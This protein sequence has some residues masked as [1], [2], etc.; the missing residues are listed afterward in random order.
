MASIYICGNAV[1]TYYMRPLAHLSSGWCVYLCVY[2]Y[3]QN[4]SSVLRNTS[5]LVTQTDV[6][7]DHIAISS[8][9]R[10]CNDYRLTAYSILTIFVIIA[11]IEI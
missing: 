4:M 10:L 2:V 1:I 3:Y 7:S 6:T 8:V 5:N 11:N 9:D